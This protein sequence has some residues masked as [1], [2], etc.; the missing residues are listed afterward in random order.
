[1]NLDAIRKKINSYINVE[2]NFLYKGSRGQ[3]ERFKGSII[4]LYPRIFVI[5]TTNNKIK[6]FSYNDYIIGNIKVIHHL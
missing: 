6:S 1:M 4:K 2:C 3:F 5:K